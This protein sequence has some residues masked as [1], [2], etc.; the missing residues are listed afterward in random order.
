MESTTESAVRRRLR[1]LTHHLAPR[2]RQPS[3]SHHPA[4]AAAAAPPPPEPQHLAP[5]QLAAFARDGYL[6]LSV[7]R[8]LPSGFCDAFAAKAWRLRDSLGEGGNDDTNG[9]G[10]FTDEIRSL[11][12]TP[13]CHGALRSILGPGFVACAGADTVHVSSERDQGWHAD[14]TDH[15]GTQATVRDH[16]SRHA[17]LLFYPVDTTEGMGPT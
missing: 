16:F 13:S 10:A 11:L 3:C 4:A 5:A 8:E 9:L 15:G 7:D 12:R 17:L 14:G 2:H 6:A 1:P